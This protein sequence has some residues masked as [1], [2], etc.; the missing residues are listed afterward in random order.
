MGS[1]RER[2][3][4]S[5]VCLSEGCLSGGCLFEGWLSGGWLSGGYLSGGLWSEGLLISPNCSLTRNRRD[6]H[7]LLSILPTTEPAKTRAK[8]VTTAKNYEFIYISI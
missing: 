1:P 7:T 3:H 6:Q 2:I 8:V 5:E 4:L